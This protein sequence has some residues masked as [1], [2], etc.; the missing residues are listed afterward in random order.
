MRTWDELARAAQALLCRA[1]KLREQ[2][3]GLV[4]EA[5]SQARAAYRRHDGLCEQSRGLSRRRTEGA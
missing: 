1:A 5:V 2:S 3:R 4:R